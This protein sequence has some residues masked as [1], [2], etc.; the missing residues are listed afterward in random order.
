[1]VRGG[2]LEPPLCWVKASGLT[3]LPI[4]DQSYIR[5]QGPG[6][7]P[8]LF[9]FRARRVTASTIPVHECDRRGGGPAPPPHVVS[10]RGRATTHAAL[11]VSAREREH[12]EL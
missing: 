8:G 5:A 9:A 3:S 12:A 11:R 4:P 6:L 10:L 7:E 2:G 1:M